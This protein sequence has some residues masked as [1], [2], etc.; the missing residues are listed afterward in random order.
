MGLDMGKLAR[1]K[2]KRLDRLGGA[3]EFDSQEAL[4][5]AL[6]DAAS[7]GRVETVMQCL[8]SGANPKA[9]DTAGLTALMCAAYEADIECLKVL[10]PVSDLMDEDGSGNTALSFA[11]RSPEPSTALALIEGFGKAQLEKKVMEISVV[12]PH[13][14]RPR[15]MG[16]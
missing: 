14:T 3:M 9:R 4:D 8:A 1:M 13:P 7:F 10:L 6:L 12:E 16:L 5:N 15:R 11:A 2:I